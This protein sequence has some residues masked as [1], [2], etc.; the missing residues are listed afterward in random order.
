MKAVKLKNEEISGLCDALFSLIHAG[1]GVGDAFALL[2]QDEPQP[3]L[4]ELFADMARHADEGM[5][6]AQIFREIGCVPDYVCGLLEAGG[7]VGKTEQTLEALAHHYAGRSRMEQ[8]LRAAL[9]YPSVLL[10]VML[11]V[12]VVLL[13]WVLP[14]FNDVYAQ[15]G[16]RLTGVA[17]G[18][19]LLGKML[20]GAMPALG[21][22]LAVLV[23]VL[24]LFCNSSALR[25]RAGAL[26]H[27]VWGHR[28]VAGK[29]GIARIAQALALGLSSGLTDQESAALT[30]ALTPEDSP[31]RKKCEACIDCLDGGDSLAAALRNTGLL[32]ASHCRLLE[33]GMRSGRGEAVM[34]QIARQLLEESEDALET[35]VGRIE[36]AL[37]IVTS[38]LV[39]VIL[40]TVMLPLMHILSGIG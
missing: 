1:I 38:V 36:P 13:V 20:R 2:Q 25:E 11:A 9:L 31:L 32:S 21:A 18:L 39:G 27:R 28:G 16:S 3:T 5:P 10:V 8:R 29:I 12:I 35:L 17:G 26:W 6:L 23:V 33:A 37:V 24:V 40:L 7:R 15:L 14:V 30:L 22:V 34:E 4:R 19:L